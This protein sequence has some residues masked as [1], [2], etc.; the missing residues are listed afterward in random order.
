MFT[1]MKIIENKFSAQATLV[2]STNEKGFKLKS[3]MVSEEH[4]GVGSK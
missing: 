2:I 1:Q 3:L 4:H